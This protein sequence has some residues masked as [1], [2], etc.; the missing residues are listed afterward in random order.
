M[1]FDTLPSASDD[2]GESGSV[3]VNDKD[4]APIQG[5]I[6]ASTIA[7]SFAYDGNTQGGRTAATNA[8]VKVVAGNP[9]F[10]KPVV[11]NYTITRT[12]GQNI[13][14]TAEQDRAYRNQT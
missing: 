5:I 13:A 7:W 11:T 2:W 8:A 4:G 12:V 9:G 6:N 10:G 14:L 3:T 1:Y